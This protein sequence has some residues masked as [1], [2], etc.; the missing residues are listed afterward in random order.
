MA[1]PVKLDEE[2]AEYFYKDLQ[3][4]FFS[5]KIFIYHYLQFTRNRLCAC[6]GPSLSGCSTNASH[7][8]KLNLHHMCWTH[9]VFGLN[10]H[11]AHS[12]P[13]ADSYT[14]A[15]D[16]INRRG[17]AATVRR[18]R[19]TFDLTFRFVVGKLVVGEA[20]P[21]LLEV[22]HSKPVSPLRSLD[23]KSEGKWVKETLKTLPD[24]IYIK[25]IT[26]LLFLW[27]YAS[28]IYVYSKIVQ[29]INI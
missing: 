25:Y 12:H 8:H 16:D 29:H 6:F 19:E 21:S 18:S 9:I 22:L 3:L 4:K 13:P 5:P 15:R 10:V 20:K 2:K 1:P 28:L 24:S 23:H 11:S 17:N 7:A 27:H 26:I 14:S